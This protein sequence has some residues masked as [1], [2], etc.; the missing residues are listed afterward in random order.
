[1]NAKLSLLTICE[2]SA[3]ERFDYELQKV[4]NNIVDPNTEAKTTREITITVKIKPDEARESFSAEMFVKSKLAKLSAVTS[5]GAIGK[6]VRGLAEAFEYSKPK[7]QE[8]PFGNVT[9]MPAKGKESN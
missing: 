4:L 5:I 8:I 7:Q 9:H 6:D 2:G 3:A 1:M